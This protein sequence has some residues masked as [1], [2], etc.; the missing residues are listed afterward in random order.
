MI[1]GQIVCSVVELETPMI[2]AVEVFDDEGRIDALPDGGEVRPIEGPVGPESYNDCATAAEIAAAEV[3]D[4]EATS[5]TT[6]ED[7]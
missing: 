2:S 5:T 6:D 4:D 3:V 7:S 1:Y